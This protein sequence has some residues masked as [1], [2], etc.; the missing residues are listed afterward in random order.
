MQNILSEIQAR[1][2]VIDLSARARFQLSGSDRVRYLNG[3][4]SND[5]RKLKAEASL[6][7]CVM[8]AKGKMCADVFISSSADFL[9]IDTE[10]ELRESLAARLE[11]YIIADDC[12]LTDVTDQTAHYFEILPGTIASAGASLSHSSHSSHAASPR[13]LSR[14]FGFEGYDHFL[15]RESS[16]TAWNALAQ[17]RLVLDARTAEIL[18]IENGVPRWG[19]EL[20]EHVLPMEAGLDATAIDFNKGCYIGQEIISRIKSLGHVNRRLC[21]FESNS[22]LLPG[23]E[24][25]VDDSDKPVGLLTSA[26]F[27]FTRPVALGYLKRGV[28]L[29][30]LTARSPE[31]SPT[32]PACPPCLVE[33]KELHNQP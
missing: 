6:Y 32:G 15:P 12:Q 9:R 3:Q 23:M 4:V 18:R 33:T 1:G 31:G 17:E 11:R 5:V 29:T 16:E 28:D 22:E 14:R 20:D 8:T 2:T 7:A 13:V 19:Y 10:P 27:G 21:R 24:L 30:V 26:T 25:F